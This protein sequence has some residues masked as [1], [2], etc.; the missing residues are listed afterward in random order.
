MQT[1]P[2][3]A[4]THLIFDSSNPNNDIKN[5]KFRILWPKFNAKYL[6][7]AVHNPKNDVFGILLAP[8]SSNVSECSI[9]DLEFI[10]MFIFVRYI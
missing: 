10:I 2:Y 6:K 7:N 9:W 4:L 1:T 8:C 3:I 5:P